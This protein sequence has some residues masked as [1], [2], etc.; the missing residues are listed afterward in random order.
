MTAAPSELTQSPSSGSTRP[1]GPVP[2]R[3]LAM[4]EILDGAV[5]LLRLYPGATLGVGAAVMAV[6]LLLTTPIQLD[7]MV[8]GTI[9]AICYATVFW[10]IA[11]WRFTRKDVTS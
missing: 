4:G 6:Q 7:G 1:H 10:G 11:F 8:K 2:I 3:P 5:L 9:S